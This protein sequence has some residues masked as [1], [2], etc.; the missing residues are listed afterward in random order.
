VAGE[1]AVAIAAA[2]TEPPP[3]EAAAPELPASAPAEPVPPVA[4][5]IT[6]EGTTVLQ[7]PAAQPV[8][9][10][11]PAVAGTVPVV[12]AQPVV[13]ETITYTAGGAVQLGGGGQPGAVLR[14][15]LDTVPVAE[16]TV[17][18]GG[19]W[20]VTLDDIA[21]GTYTLRADQ[22]DAAG[23]VTARFETP[24]R[25]ETPEAL[26]AVAGLPAPTDPAAGTDSGTEP[27]AG[28]VTPEAVAAAAPAAATPAPATASD[29]TAADT[30][31][32]DAVTP[33]VMAEAPAEPAAPA[34][35]L[36]ASAVP[37]AEPT[38]TVAAAPEPVPAPAPASAA[39]KL[40]VSVTVQPGFTLWAIARDHL[41]EGILYVQ[42]FEANKDKI[43]DP[44]LIYPGQVFAIP[45]P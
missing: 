3:A 28:V 18:A 45:D 44:N 15:Y 14:F 19:K 12:Q 5:K 4:L 10:A 6:E 36:P 31:A 21:P 35:D 17:P 26:A 25:R 32:A 1:P 39:P 38:G 8:P 42:V 20:L 22:I 11:A 37:A 40:P 30:G 2:A 16:T 29:A 34:P 9:V 7:N 23:K 41:G 24:F 27:A 33:A 43:R 13:I